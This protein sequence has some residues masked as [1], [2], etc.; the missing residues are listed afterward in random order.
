MGILEKI[1]EIE[2]EIAR[3]QK[4]KGISWPRMPRMHGHPGTFP[5]Y[6]ELLAL[7]FVSLPPATEGHLGILK[8]K[9]A[10]YRTQ[11]MEPPK[12]ASSKVWWATIR[13]P[14]QW[15]QGLTQFIY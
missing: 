5:G 12:G 8:A 2:K 10:K 6:L 7:L 9:L 14:L 1:A 15:Y 4:N 13:V 11:L 3:T